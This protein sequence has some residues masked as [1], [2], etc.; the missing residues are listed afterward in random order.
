MTEPIREKKE[1][2][3]KAGPPNPPLHKH[4][5]PAYTY[6]HTYVYNAHKVKEREKEEKEGGREEGTG[7]KEKGATKREKERET[8]HSIAIKQNGKRK[9]LGYNNVHSVHSPMT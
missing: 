1:N 9:R 7:E 6:T 2:S 3:D 4:S 5:A 8:T